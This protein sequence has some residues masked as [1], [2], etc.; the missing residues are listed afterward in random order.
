MKDVLYVV[1]EL[2]DY[3]RVD[4]K[5]KK[6]VFLSNIPVK[7]DYTNDPRLI[8]YLLSFVQLRLAT[9]KELDNTKEEKPN[10]ESSRRSYRY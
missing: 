3:F 2:S 10:E 9:A 1:N 6:Y 7:V 5:G 4:Y 8:S